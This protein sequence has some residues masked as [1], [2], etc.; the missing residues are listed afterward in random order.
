MC[1]QASLLYSEWPNGKGKGRRTAVV[2]SRNSH[3]SLFCISTTV[4]HYMYEYSSYHIILKWGGTTIQHVQYSIKRIASY[5]VE[6]ESLL[7]YVRVFLFFRFC[8]TLNAAGSFV[9]TR[10]VVSINVGKSTL[11]PVVYC[12]IISLSGGFDVSFLSPFPSLTLDVM[13]CFCPL[14]CSP[15]LCCAVRSVPYVLCAPF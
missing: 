1:K 14:L 8:L 9:R 7:Q 11:E 13:S 3:I 12:S 15:P 5:K 10:W 2:H 6:W 4:Q